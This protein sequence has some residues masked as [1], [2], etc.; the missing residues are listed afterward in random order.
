EH[1]CDFELKK[2]HVTCNKSAA[3]LTCDGCQQAFCGKH[4]NEH[5]QDLAEQN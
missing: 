2:K 4:A 1:E 5:Q 3:S